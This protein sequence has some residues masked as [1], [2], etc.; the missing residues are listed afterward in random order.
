[1][2]QLLSLFFD[3]DERK[4]VLTTF[5]AENNLLEVADVIGTV[6]Y[7]RKMLCTSDSI[8]LYTAWVFIAS[9]MVAIAQEFIAVKTE[10]RKFFGV[11]S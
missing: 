11:F 2:K 7:S 9:Q 4:Q 10:H 3:I 8:D 6:I 1:M 5:S